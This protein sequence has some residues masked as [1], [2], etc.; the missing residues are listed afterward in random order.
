MS[1]DVGWKTSLRTAM[2]AARGPICNLEPGTL[3]DGCQSL[4]VQVPPSW[5]ASAGSGQWWKGREVRLDPVLVAGTSTTAAARHLSEL[6]SKLELVPVCRSAAF[7]GVESPTRD[8]VKQE[9]SRKARCR[10]TS[11]QEQFGRRWFWGQ[12]KTMEGRSA[13][14]G[15][16][17]EDWTMRRTLDMTE[18]GKE[19]EVG[20]RLASEW[21][22][23]A[24]VIAVHICTCVALC[25][26]VLYQPERGRGASNA[27]SP[28][29]QLIGTRVSKMQTDTGGSS[30]K[31]IEFKLLRG[32]SGLEQRETGMTDMDVEL[33]ELIVCL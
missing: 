5:V 33:P 20:A 10:R 17:S 21:L 29:G 4:Q 2:V 19:V 26:P 13:P 8:E 3:A 14:G 31:R 28:D 7:E 12:G 16:R 1:L 27:R 23:P 11:R 18:N 6:G 32:A 22:P 15:F 24:E 30:V 9:R 25:W